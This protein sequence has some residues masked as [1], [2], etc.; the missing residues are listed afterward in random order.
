MFFFS[1]NKIKCSLKVPVI[2]LMLTILRA[3]LGPKLGPTPISIFPLFT[4]NIPNIRL[5]QKADQNF[6]LF[7]TPQFNI[8]LSIGT[9][10]ISPLSKKKIIDL[11]TCQFSYPQQNKF[12][13]S[14]VFIYNKDIENR[15]F[16]KIRCEDPS[17]KPE[18]D[19]QKIY[20]ILK[21]DSKIIS[22][23]SM[24]LLLQQ[25]GQ[26]KKEKPA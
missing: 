12:V 8:Y 4:E 5:N 17:W 25:A 20:K 6:P 21:I 22:Y 7:S 18:L 3:N 23:M 2:L 9:A 13:L 14:R 19:L 10:T 15:F 11:L 24:Y 16:L 1:L 26:Q